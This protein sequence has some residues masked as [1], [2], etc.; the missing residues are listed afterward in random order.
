[1]FE[2]KAKTT[3]KVKLSTPPLL[4]V[5][6][7]GSAVDVFY[8]SGFRAVDPVVYLSTGKKRHLVVPPLEL[9]RAASTCSGVQ[10]HTPAGL[11]LD[12]KQQRSVQAWAMGLL[13]HLGIRRVRVNHGFPLGLGRALEATGIRIDV[14]DGAAFPER[15]VKSSAELLRIAQ[16]QQAAA[17]AV[18]AARELIAAAR[19]ARKGRDRGVLFLGREQLTSERLR[20]EIRQCLLRH[21]CGDPA[22]TIVACGAQAA[23]PHE[24]GY[25]PLR[26]GQTIVIDIFP[27]HRGHGYWGDIT[28]TFVKGRATP[29]QRAMYKAVLEAQE[30]ALAMVRAG[31]EA[32][33][34]HKKVSDTLVAHGFQ[35]KVSAK[36]AEGFFHGT[37]HGVGLDIHE[38]P[39]ISTRQVVLRA[40]NVVTVE[41]GLYY[42][43]HGGVRIEDTVA[44]TRAGHKILAEYPKELEV[45]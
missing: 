27:Q 39:S 31:V 23:D 2:M 10:V 25:G 22:D 26:A 36:T 45:E 19:V 38:A 40:G 14:M 20:S 4:L 34:I 12:L 7:P 44:V 17:A 21:D 35:T 29:V 37:G 1:M 28:R 32:S 8:G 13:R 16:A 3:A 42:L 43:R 24:R 41:P 5:A 6:E 30:C 9:G 11:G 33:D 15:Q 18:H